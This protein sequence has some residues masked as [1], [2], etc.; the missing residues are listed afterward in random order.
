MTTMDP[1]IQV[2][3]DVPESWH[4]EAEILEFVNYGQNV[5]KRQMREIELV[6]PRKSIQKKTKR[7]PKTKKIN[8]NDEEFNQFV[9]LVLD[10]ANTCN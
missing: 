3:D 5:G 1:S 2:V 10:K 9:K 7:G 6:K 4:V 8:S